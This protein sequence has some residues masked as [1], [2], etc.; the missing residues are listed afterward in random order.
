MKKSLS[1]DFRGISTLSFFGALVGRYANRIANRRFTLGGTT[2]SLPQ[3]DLHNTLHG[4]KGF[5]RVVWK[6]KPIEN[7]VE[8]THLSVDGDQ[9][10]PGNL[11]VTVRYT[12]GTSLRIEYSVTTDKPIVVNLTNLFQ[13]RGSGE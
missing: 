1:K 13:S 6:A 5:D 2:Y 4:G 10:F 11:A 7:G 12:L 8:L 3:N 9:G